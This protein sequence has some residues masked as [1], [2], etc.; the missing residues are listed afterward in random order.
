MKV[1]EFVPFLQ[2]NAKNGWTNLQVKK[3]QSGKIYVELDTFEPKAKE[4]TPAP[5]PVQSPITSSQGDLL[6]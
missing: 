6:F 4:Q 3:S 1:E 2:A 5:V